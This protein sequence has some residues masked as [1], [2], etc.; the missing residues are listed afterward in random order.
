MSPA[1]TSAPTPPH[2]PKHE[3]L[4]GRIA[5]DFCN[6][7]SRMRRKGP[8]DRILKPEDFFGWAGRCGFALQRAPG[9]QVLARLHRLRAALFGIFDALLDD[10]RP[11]DAHL[12][13]LNAELAGARTA[14]HLAQSRGTYVIEDSAPAI[15]DR[16][17]HAV[18]RDAAGLLIGDR[19]R[20]K[21][22]PAHDCLWLFYDGSKNLSRRWCAM[23]DCG[24]LDK[25]RRYRGK[26]GT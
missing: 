2:L 3:F 13:V 16:F 14:E 20:I 26:D 18:A 23:D 19:R 1:N 21:R 10:V 15:I 5:L 7:L 24:T 8:Q 11:D 6:T 12:D 17:R 9:P 25:V 22:C 4:A